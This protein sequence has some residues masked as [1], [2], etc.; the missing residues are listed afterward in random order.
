LFGGHFQTWRLPSQAA[1]ALH[2]V[3]CPDTICSWQRTLL[4]SNIAPVNPLQAHSEHLFL[5]WL[6]QAAI[7]AKK[8]LRIEVRS[9]EVVVTSSFFALLVVVIASMSF[10][11]GPVS[12]PSVAAGTLW[13]SVAFAT[14]LAL[15]RSWQ[16]EREESAYMGLLAAPLSRSALFMGKL[17][18]L[19]LFLAVVECVV[20]PLVALLFAIDLTKVAPGLLAIILCATPGIGAVGTLFG[21]MTVRTR[22]R[23]L[24]LAIVLFPL[25]A[26]TI[27]AAVVASRDLFGGAHLADLADYL[28]LMGLFDVVFLTG[29]LSMFGLLIDE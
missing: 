27:L 28:S 2:R 14:V 22:A 4:P 6:A 12:R 18:S 17:L 10:H 20:V 21:A 13:L 24:I 23:D 7:V 15:S 25:L 29:G 16:R 26:P 5:R 1:T 9:G 19:L 3:K 8:D 11:G